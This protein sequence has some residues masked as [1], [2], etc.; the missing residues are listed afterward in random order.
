LFFFLSCAVAKIFK[1]DC[2]EYYQKE[3]RFLQ[4]TANVPELEGRV[5]KLVISSPPEGYLFLSPVGVH[6]ACSE[7]EYSNTRFFATPQ[8]DTAS[9]RGPQFV[10]AKPST[11]A[12]LVSIL[13]VL[14]RTAK[15]VHRDIRANNIFQNATGQVHTYLLLFIS[16]S[17]C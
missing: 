12:E 2:L 8:P 17:V 5:S 11:F 10:R 9:P 13:E 6:F 1:P 7:V 16:A 4:A 15:I 3:L 14:H